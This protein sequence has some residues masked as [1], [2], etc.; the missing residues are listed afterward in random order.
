LYHKIDLPIDIFFALI[1]EVDRKIIN[2]L[3]T[4]EHRVK[5]TKRKSIQVYL[6]GQ[7]LK[8]RFKLIIALQF[9]RHKKLASYRLQ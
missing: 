1:A 5:H 6:N 7:F 4:Q 9:L 8:V 3:Y 2:S